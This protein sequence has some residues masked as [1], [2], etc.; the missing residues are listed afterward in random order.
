[1]EQI[2]K[3][4]E[5]I[6]FPFKSGYIV[7]NFNGEF[8]Q[9]HTHLR[10]YKACKKAI[11]YVIKKKIPRSNS[12]YYLNSLKRLSLDQDYKDKITSLIKVKKSKGKQIYR[13]RKG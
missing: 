9:N 10:N 8:K 13:N 3:K 4:N 1:M 2:Y 7:F 6:I 11:D 5:F 12:F